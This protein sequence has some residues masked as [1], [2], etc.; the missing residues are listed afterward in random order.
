[1][2]NRS[3]ALLAATIVAFASLP[4]VGA[5]KVPAKWQAGTNYTQLPSP[6]ATATAKGKV[7]VL[8]IFWYGC[9]HCYALDPTLETWKAS[10]PAYVDFTRVHVVWGP[11]HAQHAKLFYTLHALKREDLHPK[12]FEAIHDLGQTLAAQDEVVARG[13]HKKFLLDHG[14]SAKDFDAAYD[15][16]AVASQVQRAQSLT[17][18]YQVASVPVIV[19]N[20]KYMTGVN[21]AGGA[22]Q[23]LSLIND[24]A[25]SEKG[26]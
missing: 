25:A 4:A 13:M 14:V 1:M 21:Q 17:N 9:S 22:P 5:G 3:T 8:E 16:M 11:G 15:S 7:E 2:M 10:K 19:V 26:R 24:L 20:G 18:A 12:V 6:Q 23:L